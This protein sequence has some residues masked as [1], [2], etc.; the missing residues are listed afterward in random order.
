MFPN[1]KKMEVHDTST[2]WCEPLQYKIPLDIHNMLLYG[3]SWYERK[4]NATL[5]V[6][7]M[8][9]RWNTAAARLACTINH[10]EVLLLLNRLVVSQSGVLFQI[11]SRC[12]QNQKNWNHLFQDIFKEIGC[13]FF[14][15]ENLN[16][17]RNHF[18]IPEHERWI[19]TPS[20]AT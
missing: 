17:L 7:H 12:L 19:V 20:F 6:K 18:L 13:L 2:K 10:E 9:R 14:T 5:A 1:I 15:H 11:V 4:F 8:Q 16:V 3:K